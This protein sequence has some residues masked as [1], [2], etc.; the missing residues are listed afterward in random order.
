MG[1]KEWEAISFLFKNDIDST[2][3][4]DKRFEYCLKWYISHA[5]KLKFVFYCTTFS[6]AV[7]P[8]L[9]AIINTMFPQHDKGL[10]WLLGIISAFSGISVIILNATRAQE[11]WTRYREAAEFLKRQ[12][13]DFQY[14]RGSLSNQ[15]DI[16]D[17]GKKYL[18][19]IENYME[20]EN[21]KWKINNTNWNGSD[22]A[23]LRAK[24]KSGR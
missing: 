11:K 1:E 10:I 12:R 16:Y 21:D 14:K 13:T 22:E 7:C 8:L 9:A 23:K 20:E 15:D 18:N 4:L 2:D 5:C 17:L 24:S 6:G 3:V 19:I